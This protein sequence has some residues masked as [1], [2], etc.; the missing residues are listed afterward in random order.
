MTHL[1][2]RL[3]LGAAFASLS[4]CAPLVLGP[5]TRGG[6]SDAPRFEGDTFVSFDGARLPLSRWSPA[7]PVRRVIVA[8]HGMNDYAMAFQDDGPVFAAQGVAT[9]A[10]DQRGFGRGPHRGLWAGRDLLAADLKAAA[11]AARR[12]HPG[13]PV[14][15]LGHSMG[16]AVAI[17]AFADPDPPEAEALILA[18]PAIWGWNAQPPLNR[19]ALWLSAHVTPG[20]HLSPPAWVARK[21]QSSDNIPVL[22]RM[23][24][25]PNLL[26]T[27]RVDAVYGLVGLMQAAADRIGSVGAPVLYLYGANDRF[28]PRGPT[29]AAVNHLK[30][31]DRSA[32]YPD[33]WHLLLRDLHGDRVRGDILAWLENRKAA[34]PSGSMSIPEG[35]R[36]PGR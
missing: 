25:D 1:S 2:R 18:A 6:V 5:E 16:G 33:G 26:F 17:S 21:Y 19:V 15:V 7:G 11:Q 22:I 12:A 9:Y 24:R 27:T 29:L 23:G 36:S 34:F 32:F 31:S 10:Y 13:V 14:S 35:L 4:G 30:A 20:A 3:V 8:L 28:V